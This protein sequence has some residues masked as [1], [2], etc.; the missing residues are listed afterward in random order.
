MAGCGGGPWARGGWRGG[1]PGAGGGGR[2]GGGGGLGRAGGVGRGFPR[3]RLG[4]LGRYRPVR[5]GAVLRRRALGTGHDLVRR[6][7]RLLL[8]LLPVSHLRH[9]RRTA[10]NVTAAEPPRRRARPTSSA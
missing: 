10:R 1:A 6:P 2:G 9:K 4:L 3:Y 7:H 5:P 8:G